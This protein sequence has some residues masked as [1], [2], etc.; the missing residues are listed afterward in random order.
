MTPL[1]KTKKHLEN[2]LVN[3]YIYILKLSLK[4]INFFYNKT[5]N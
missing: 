1:I 4:V 5:E 2:F 3:E